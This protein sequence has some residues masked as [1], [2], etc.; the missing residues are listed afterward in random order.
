[1]NGDDLRKD[2][3]RALALTDEEIEAAACAD[4]DNPPRS[5]EQLA[6][7]RRVP[8]VQRI[9]RKLGLSQEAFAER[10]R[11]PLGTVRDWELHRSEPDQSAKAYLAVI[12]QE[13]ETVVRALS[14]AAE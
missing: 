10:F 6:R 13:P 7:F 3:A 12:D 8:A 2:M 4:P 9:R 14:L 5:S 11:I 1:M